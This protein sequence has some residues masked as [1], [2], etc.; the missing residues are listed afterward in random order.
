MAISEDELVK[1]N[2]LIEKQVKLQSELS[3]LRGEDVSKTRQ[4][5]DTL[6]EQ[7]AMAQE[8]YEIASLEFENDEK[9]VKFYEQQE[10]FLDKQLQAGKISFEQQQNTKKLLD[11]IQAAQAAGDQDAIEAAKK[12]LT[13]QQS[14]TSEMLASSRAA[15]T[16]A[17][18]VARVVGFDDQA[19]K[20][21]QSFGAAFKQPVQFAKVFG[22]ELGD[23]VSPSGVFGQVIANTFL[24]AGGLARQEAAFVAATG[25]TQDFKDDVM[26]LK[27]EF[28]ELVSVLDIFPVLTQLNQGFI[29]FKDLAKDTQMEMSR[30]TIALE[31]FG[32]ASSQ[33]ADI[34][35]ELVKRARLLPEEA[36]KALLTVASLSEETSFPL[37]EIVDSF[38]GAQKELSIFGPRGVKIFG[39]LAK[40]ASNMG[41]RVG[42]GTQM[43]LK[44]TQ[45]FDTFESAASKV[46]TINAF[47]GGSFIDTYSMVMAT[48]EGPP[49]QLNLLQSALDNAGI[50]ADNF[51]DN[52][53]KAKGLADGFGVSVDNLR[54]FM[55]GEIDE[56]EVFLTTQDKMNKLLESAVDPMTKLSNAV[57]D[58]SAFVSENADNF[59]TLLSGVTKLVDFFANNLA[60]QVIGITYMLSGV[61]GPALLGL[62]PAFVGIGLAIA[63]IAGFFYIFD[64]LIDNMAESR[65]GALALGAALG[66]ISGAVMG[67]IKGFVMSGGNPLGALAGGLAGAFA[68][69]S[70]GALGGTLAY[71]EPDTKTVSQGIGSISTNPTMQDGFVQTDSQGN[72]TITPISRKDQFYSAKEGGAIQKAITSNIAMVANSSEKAQ[73][74]FSEKDSKLLKDFI[75]AVKKDR[76]R[77]IQVSSTVKMPNGRVL[78]EV[79]N[80]QNDNRY[81]RRLY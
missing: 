70:V 61:L 19:V 16:L 32:I 5:M 60:G 41:L 63:G 11:D 59:N 65:E 68:G 79:V 12:K 4:T 74:G 22:Q 58:L 3:R 27:S 2:E 45:G 17:N 15:A 69:G 39:Q 54:A 64:E 24:L 55:S 30:A 46:A 7:S 75:D 9:R 8:L 62:K 43:L 57:Q 72:A 35:N 49:A 38:Q 20:L 31:G 40:S 67:A 29:G 13:A 10:K 52:I 80:E 78:A 66:A 50:T 48:A 33:S 28:G 47:L 23:L 36:S 34:L 37:N 77:P 1:Q 42:E 14:I 73:G 44:M 18:N 81:N 76:D 53:F 71:D 56:T 25:I 51:G 26:S 21:G 6:R